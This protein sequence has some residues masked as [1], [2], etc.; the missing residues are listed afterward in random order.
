MMREWGSLAHADRRDVRLHV[1]HG[2]VDRHPRRHR[3]AR[4]VDVEIDV[5]VGII[6]LEEEHLRD[7][8][9][10]DLVLDV[11]GKEDDPLLE[12][13]GEDV[14]RPLPAGRLLDHHRNQAHR[15]PPCHIQ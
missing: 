7:H 6:G 13:T 12:E 8:E 3:A 14:E 9:V 10:R 5:L 15:T 1:L 11:G 2:V 4:R